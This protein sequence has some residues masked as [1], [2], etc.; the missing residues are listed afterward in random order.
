MAFF[1]RSFLLLGAIVWLL[2]SLKQL[3]G[4]GVF[5]NPG[6][7]RDNLTLLAQA[8]VAMVVIKTSVKAKD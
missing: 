3:V 7:V 1:V 4:L 2:V 8:L 5:E 6:L